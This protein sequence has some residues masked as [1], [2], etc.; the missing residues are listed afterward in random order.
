MELTEE[1]KVVADNRSLWKPPR[2]SLW[3]RR[4]LSR[5]SSAISPKD[6]RMPRPAPARVKNLP[7][8]WLRT[9]RLMRRNCKHGWIN[10]PPSTAN[11]RPLT[12]KC[13]V[14]NAATLADME[15]KTNQPN[16]GT[17]ISFCHVIAFI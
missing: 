11:W 16:H 5:K 17:W 9:L 15:D 6:S 14:T 2:P 12:T 3:P 1:Y 4:N 10:I 7:P 13:R 8:H